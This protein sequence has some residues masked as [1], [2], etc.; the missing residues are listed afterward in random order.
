MSIPDTEFEAIISKWAHEMGKRCGYKKQTRMEHWQE[1]IDAVYT[2]LEHKLQTVDTQTIQSH[3]KW[4][5]MMLAAKTHFPE[6]IG[7]YHPTLVEQQR[8]R[9]LVEN[10]KVTRHLQNK[11]ELLKFLK[12]DK[13]LGVKTITDLAVSRLQCEVLATSAEILTNRYKSGL[14]KKPT[15]FA[16]AEAEASYETEK[17]AGGRC[18][19]SFRP[20][21][22]QRGCSGRL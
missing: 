19:F 22:R 4:E 1:A 15:R 16:D 14:A 17:G 6:H 11:A 12:E 2:A 18:R 20:G 7:L 9:Q 8:T 21:F 5:I 3:K 10:S 13:E